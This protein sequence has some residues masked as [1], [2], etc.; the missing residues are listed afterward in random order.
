LD[1]VQKSIVKKLEYAQQQYKVALHQ[2]DFNRIQQDIIAERME[3]LEDEIH[4]YTV[5]LNNY[6]GQT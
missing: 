4:E 2:K 6:E 1:D 5:F 3:E